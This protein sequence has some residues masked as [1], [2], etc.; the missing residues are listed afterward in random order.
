MQTQTVNLLVD[1]SLVVPPE[2]NLK[3]HVYMTCLRCLIWEASEQP[4]MSIAIEY[5]L[6]FYQ[7]DI[8]EVPTLL[9]HLI[10][11]V[12]KITERHFG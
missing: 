12:N 11:K 8:I 6:G 10:K 4:D 3:I 7:T 1:L 2:I 5:C 9:R